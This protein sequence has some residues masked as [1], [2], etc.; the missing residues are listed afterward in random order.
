MSTD[1]KKVLIQ[2]LARK[3][4]FKCKRTRPLQEIQDFVLSRLLDKAIITRADIQNIEN[5]LGPYNN[6]LVHPA[7]HKNL[8]RSKKGENAREQY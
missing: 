8:I 6:E 2:D 4:Y 7:Y 5:E 1:T 3:I